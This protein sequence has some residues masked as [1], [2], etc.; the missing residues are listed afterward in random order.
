MWQSGLASEGDNIDHGCVPERA[1]DW[2]LIVRR[3]RFRIDPAGRNAYGTATGGCA[4][5]ATSDDNISV[6]GKASFISFEQS[7][8]RNV[9]AMYHSID[10][11]ASVTPRQLC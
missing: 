7:S 6:A 4:H 9:Y 8:H 5:A 2:S 10:T 11:I 3:K 1:F